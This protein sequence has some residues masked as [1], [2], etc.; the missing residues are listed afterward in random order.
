[1]VKRRRVRWEGHVARIGRREMRRE[2]G[3]G[4]L[5]TFSLERPKVRWDDKFTVDVTKTSEMA[6]SV[7]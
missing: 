2:F 6:A 3:W 5:T 1:V 4:N 7:W